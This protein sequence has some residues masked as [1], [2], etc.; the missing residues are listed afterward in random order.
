MNKISK[1]FIGIH[2]SLEAQ[3]HKR[4]WVYALYNMFKHFAP[5]FLIVVPILGIIAN[6][7]AVIIMNYAGVSPSEL[8]NGEYTGYSNIKLIFSTV[9]SSGCLFML[10]IYM[11]IYIIQFLRWVIKQAYLASKTTIKIWNES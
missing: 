6:T 11:F 9:F 3:E 1:F 10:I 4:F 2:S 5:I 8:G 7:I